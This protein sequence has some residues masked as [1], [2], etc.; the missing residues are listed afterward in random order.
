MLEA[1][2]TTILFTQIDAGGAPR[3]QAGQGGHVEVV[4]GAYG[5]L[6]K[7]CLQN[8]RNAAVILERF[9]LDTE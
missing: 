4:Y 7:S 5:L 2:E 3:T 8:G 1:V 6:D 9:G